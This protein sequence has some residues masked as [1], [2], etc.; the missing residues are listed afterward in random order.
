MGLPQV[1]QG[2]IPWD[3]GTQRLTRLVG[4]TRSL[5]LLLTGQIIDS[6]KALEIGLINE[7]TNAG[8][9]LSIALHLAKDIAQNVKRKALVIFESTTSDRKKGI[10]S[11]S[12]R[13]KPKFTCA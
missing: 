6:Q 7:I 13:T 8:L 11:F 5:E 1:N 3:G 9:G 4:R 2:A 10:V 12:K